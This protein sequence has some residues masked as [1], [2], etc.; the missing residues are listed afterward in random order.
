MPKQLLDDAQVRAAGQQMG[1]ERV[2]QRVRADPPRQARPICRAFD[3]RPGL[4]AGEPTPPDGEEQRTASE[5]GDVT[6]REPGRPDRV[7]VA[8]QP[9]DGRVA[10]GHQAFLVALA[11]DPH[12]SPLEREILAVEAERLADPETGR[13]EQFQE[14]PVPNVD[15]VVRGVPASGFQQPRCI[16]HIERVRQV[17]GLPWQV[18]PSGQIRRD[19]LVAV[20]EAVEATDRGRPAAQAGGSQL[21]G[22]RGQVTRGGLGRAV[23]AGGHGRVRRK[24]A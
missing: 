2:P 23:P 24:P 5:R 11:N 8:F 14:S 12:E 4:L 21:A 19:E 22:C 16:G 7:E 1:G 20:G 13:V 17:T 15:G 18:D 9:G 3:D 6:Q 10:Q